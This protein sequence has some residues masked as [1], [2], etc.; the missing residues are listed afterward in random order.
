MLLDVVRS[1]D[2]LIEVSSVTPEASN[3]GV[4]L[5]TSIFKV[6][7]VGPFT[8]STQLINQNLRVSCLTTLSTHAAP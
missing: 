2:D 1:E 8:L 4:T 3:E 5:E 6:L 7:C